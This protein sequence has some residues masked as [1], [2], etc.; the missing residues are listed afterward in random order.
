VRRLRSRDG[1]KLQPLLNKLNGRGFSAFWNA[2]LEFLKAQRAGRD[3]NCESTTVNRC[4]PGC[5]VGLVR[6]EEVVEKVPDS[7]F[8]QE[9]LAD[10]SYPQFNSNLMALET[11]A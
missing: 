10:S 2:K 4:D 11:G 9:Q 3:E 1:Y 6:K 5:C 7:A 8:L